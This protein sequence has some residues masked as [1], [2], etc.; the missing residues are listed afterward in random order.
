[1]WY[2]VLTTCY[3]EVEGQVG[4]GGCKGSIW[5]KIL[6]G[7]REGDN[8]EVGNWFKDNLQRRVGNG[9]STSFWWDLW[10]EGEALKDRFSRLFELTENK[11]MSVVDMS[12]LAENAVLC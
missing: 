8:I 12:M 9:M 3:G 5:W 7:I 1:L 11:M 4:D 10:F 2:R 6:V